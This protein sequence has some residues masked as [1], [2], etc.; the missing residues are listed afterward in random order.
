MLPEDFETMRIPRKIVSLD[1]LIERER[2]PKKKDHGCICVALYKWQVQNGANWDKP[3][4]PR[5][6]P[7]KHIDSSIKQG[8]RSFAQDTKRF[9]RFR[10]DAG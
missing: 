5:L 7:T 1:L 3:W 4:D 10:N 9:S 8:E 6:V 2:N